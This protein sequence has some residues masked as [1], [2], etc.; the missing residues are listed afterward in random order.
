MSVNYSLTI[1][2]LDTETNEVKVPLKN[3]YFN[4]WKSLSDLEKFYDGYFYSSYDVPNS[5]VKAVKDELSYESLEYKDSYLKSDIDHLKFEEI[6]RHSHSGVLSVLMDPSQLEGINPAEVKIGED[7]SGLVDVYEKIKKTYNGSFY[8]SAELG[9]NKELILN[10]Y[11]NVVARNS[12]ISEY[13]N[14]IDFLKI[15]ED[16]V[17]QNIY[18]E[19]NSLK[20]SQDDWEWR[21]NSIITLCGLVDVYGEDRYNVYAFIT[22]DW[23]IVD[24]EEEK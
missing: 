6:P 10:E 21:L 16:E 9:R 17:K 5:V 22:S 23:D 2:V 7:N 14:S 24:Y 12:K 8:Y 18:D 1:A 11:K 19:L 13:V 4:H 20:E 3:A 15:V